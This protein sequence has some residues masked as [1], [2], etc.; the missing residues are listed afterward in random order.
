MQVYNLGID[1][2]THQN[3]AMIEY[4]ITNLGT[5]KLILNTQES[6]AKFSLNA[7][8]LTLE[9]SLSLAGLEPG[10]YQVKIKVNDVVSN[11]QTEESAKFSVD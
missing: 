8:Q 10:Q 4:Q 5:N 7:E 11:H 1:D 3:N 2:K 9:K 6:A